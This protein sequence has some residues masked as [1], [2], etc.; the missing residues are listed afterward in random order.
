[1]Q[2]CDPRHETWPL[3][4]KTYTLLI[5]R[6]ESELREARGIPLSWMDVLIQLSKTADGRMPMNQLASSV[7]LSKSG[8]TRLIDK[9]VEAGLVTRAS[10][11]T[12][13]RIVYA[14]ITTKGRAAFDKAGKIHFAGV[15]DHFTALLSPAETAAFETA[16][17]KISDALTAPS[18]ER[19][20]G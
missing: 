18:E 13:R 14:S 12:D 4:L 1:M 7:L 17:R 20:A 11:P 19:A 16:L 10:C 15:Q 3:F 8:L 2:D 5:D 9:M 6:L